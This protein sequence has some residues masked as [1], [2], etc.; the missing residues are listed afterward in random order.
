MSGRRKS[1]VLTHDTRA[2]ILAAYA[3]LRSAKAVRER[4]GISGTT[5]KAVL[6]E[7]RGP[8]R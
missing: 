3:E 4:F 5:L 1:E 8:A 6:R 7:A 2:R